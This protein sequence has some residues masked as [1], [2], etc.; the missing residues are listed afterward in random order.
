MC[1]VAHVL[2]L[3]VCNA[4][5]SD[6]DASQGPRNC[7]LP[8]CVSPSVPR[9]REV[10]QYLD[11]PEVVSNIMGA[12]WPILRAYKWQWTHEAGVAYLVFT[13]FTEFICRLSPGS[14]TSLELG[15]DGIATLC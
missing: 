10:F 4:M 1:C 8:Y 14:C 13:V 12:V 5:K 2:C 15:G 9:A 3:L 7:P 11:D 6:T